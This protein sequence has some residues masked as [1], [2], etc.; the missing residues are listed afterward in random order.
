[1]TLFCCNVR[2]IRRVEDDAW[3][4]LWNRWI[5]YG[6]LCRPYIIFLFIDWH[7]VFVDNLFFYLG[8]QSV[9]CKASM[10]ALRLYGYF[11][12]FFLLLSENKYDDDDR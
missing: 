6:L 2:Q 3:Y 11:C 1:M 10:A 8:S 7:V 5:R 4:K 9:S 12:D